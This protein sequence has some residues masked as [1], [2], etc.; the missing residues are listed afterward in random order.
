MIQPYKRTLATRAL[1]IYI[2][3]R[4]FERPKTLQF[5][6]TA[7]NIQ[8][9]LINLAYKI[10]SGFILA[11]VNS[12]PK[13]LNF[14]TVSTNFPYIYILELQLTYIAYVLS[15]FIHRAFSLQNCSKQETKFYNS[16]GDEAKRTTSSAKDSMNNYSDAIVYA[17]RFVCSMLHL[18]QYYCKYGYT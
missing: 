6:L 11:F 5:V 17:C 18:L 15:R 7:Q 12:I 10:P 13:Y 9:A 2:F 3:T 1:M 4:A 14:S 16:S 8:L